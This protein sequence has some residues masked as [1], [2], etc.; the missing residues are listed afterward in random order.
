M[1]NVKDITC[2]SYH[3]FIIKNDGGILGVWFKF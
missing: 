3:T 1:D 2:G